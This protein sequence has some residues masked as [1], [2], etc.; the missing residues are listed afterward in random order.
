MNKGMNMVGEFELGY[1]ECVQNVGCM[2]VGK[3][4][5]DEDGFE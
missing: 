3:G 4:Y 1:V 5:G 2:E